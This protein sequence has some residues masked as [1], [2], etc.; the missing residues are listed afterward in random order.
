[1][2]RFIIAL[3][4]VPCALI[5]EDFLVRDE[6]NTYSDQYKELTFDFHDREL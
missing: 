2:N 1:L 6:F 3:S 4:K 5:E